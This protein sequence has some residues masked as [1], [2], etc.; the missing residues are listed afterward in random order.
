MLILSLIPASQYGTI[1]RGVILDLQMPAMCTF[2]TLC[3][4]SQRRKEQTQHSPLLAAVGTIAEGTASTGDAIIAEEQQLD[5]DKHDTIDWGTLILRYFG[6]YIVFEAVT[7]LMIEP[8]VYY[9]MGVAMPHGARGV[10]A[11]LLDSILRVASRQQKCRQI[12]ICTFTPYETV[13]YINGLK[14]LIQAGVDGGR[15]E[16]L[17][18]LQARVIGTKVASYGIAWLIKC[19]IDIGTLR[20]SVG[21]P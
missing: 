18:C 1:Y 19:T 9:A 11:A 7:V 8:I 12:L 13:L 16:G 4:R 15:N 5:E 14:I 21:F 10:H 3:R 17:G 6:G 2:K 20:E